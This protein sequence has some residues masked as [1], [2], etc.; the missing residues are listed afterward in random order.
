MKKGILGKKLGMTQVFTKSGKMIPV[1]VVGVEPNIVTQIKTTESDGYEAI[2]LGFDNKR[3]KLSNRPEQGHVKKAKTTP[4]RF[5]REIRDVDA[6]AYTLGQEV[7]AEI[8]TP[9]EMVDVTG[10]SKGKGFQGVIKRHNF[11]RGPMTRGSHFHRRVGS[12]GSMRAKRVFRGKKMPGH[13]GAEQVTIQNLE[14]VMV[15]TEKNVILIKGNVPGAKKSLVMITNATKNPDTVNEFEG[16]N[17]YE[18]A[19]PKEEV[20][21]VSEN[22]EEIKTETADVTENE[23]VETAKVEEQEEQ[24]ETEEKAT[25]QEEVAEETVKEETEETEKEEKTS[26]TENETKQTAEESTDSSED[27]AEQEEKHE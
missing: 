6:K 12:L 18:Q 14:I 13:M 23:E 7:T 15:D 20:E 27:A 11:S 8:F 3:E 19:I 24:T 2:Q 16:L 17:L 1:T 9:G 25:E 4:K 26:V 5:F 22:N 10:I 21:A